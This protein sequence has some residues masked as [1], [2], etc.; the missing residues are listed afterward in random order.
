MGV[1]KREDLPLLGRAAQLR[2]AL[3]EGEAIE[4]LN[5]VLGG[6]GAASPLSPT[7]TASRMY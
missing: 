6:S 1:C 5:Y 2:Q 7:P 4:L 3:T